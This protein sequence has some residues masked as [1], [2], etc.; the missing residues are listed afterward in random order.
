MK[1]LRKG[2][3]IDGLEIV[4]YACSC[5]HLK[6]DH[7]DL[8][9]VGRKKKVGDKYVADITMIPNMGRCKKKGC[10]HCYGYDERTIVLEDG[11]I[12]DYFDYFK[13]VVCG[14]YKLKKNRSKRLYLDD[15]CISCTDVY[16]VNAIKLFKK[17]IKHMKET[18][19]T[20]TLLTYKDIQGV[21]S[22]SY[23]SFDIDE[24]FATL[25]IPEIFNTVMA[26]Y[27]DRIKF[28]EKLEKK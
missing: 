21:P 26:E 3:K 16:V 17:A 24:G 6:E 19:K 20:I 10:K 11:S 27:L 7:K 8:E 28:L 4:G 23:V 9:V 22:K 12:L 2:L 13:C 25:S 15:V 18:L 1:T 14:K 5:K